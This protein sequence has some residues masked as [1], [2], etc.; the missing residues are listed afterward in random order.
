MYANVFNYLVYI[1]CLFD[2]RVE[3]EI[4]PPDYGGKNTSFRVRFAKKKKDEMLCS[5]VDCV[6]LTWPSRRPRSTITGGN[7]EG[8]KCDNFAVFIL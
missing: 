7:C 6:F 8:I 2:S 4:G 1:L 3:N 5:P